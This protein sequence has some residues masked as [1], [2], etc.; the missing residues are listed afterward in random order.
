MHDDEQTS[1]AVLEAFRAMIAH[2]L[3]NR[4]RLELIRDQVVD[5]LEANGATVRD[6]VALIGFLIARVEHQNF[7]VG[8]ILGALQLAHQQRQAVRRGMS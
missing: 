5:V 4:G 6:V 8:D 7:D 1:E 3:E 2:V